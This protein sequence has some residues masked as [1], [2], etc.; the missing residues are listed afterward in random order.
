MTF[1]KIL[2]S[3]IFF[4]LKNYLRLRKPKIYKMYFLNFFGKMETSGDLEILMH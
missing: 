2:N 3:A 4:Y 1:K